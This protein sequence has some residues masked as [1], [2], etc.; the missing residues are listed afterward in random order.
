MLLLQKNHR[1]QYYAGNYISSRHGTQ[2]RRVHKGQYEVYAPRKWR[3][4]HRQ[5]A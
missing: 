1:K 5:N 4:T 2:A 3:A